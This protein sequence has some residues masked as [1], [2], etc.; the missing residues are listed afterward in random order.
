[1]W[2]DGFVALREEHSFASGMLHGRMPIMEEGSRLDGTVFERASG[3]FAAR[4]ALAAAKGRH[5]GRK[6]RLNLLVPNATQELARYLAVSL[7][8]ADFVHRDGTRVPADE[9]CTLL[10]GDL[11][12]VT[13]NIR[14]C[15]NLLRGLRLGHLRLTDY[16]RVEVLS[17]YTRPGDAR[18][19][20]FVANPGWR[21]TLG[22][23]RR[24]GAVVIDVSHPRTARHLPELLEQPAVS[25]SPLQVAVVPPWEEARLAPLLNGHRHARTTWA[26]DPAAAAAVEGVLLGQEVPFETPQRTIWVCDDEAV[27]E[28]LEL[29]H[30]VLMGAARLAGGRLP[31]AV[32][33]AWAVY[34]RLRQ[35]VLPLLDVEEERRRAYRT[36]PLG[37]RLER[38]S[39]VEPQ[40]G[41]SIGAYLDANWSRLVGV[42][43][44]A[45]TLLLRRAEP[46]KF[47]G[48]A[49]AVTEYLESGDA[50]NA[51]PRTP[52]RSLRVV[53][54]TEHEA[55]L[56]T[57]LMGDLV[58][59]WAEALQDGTVT[60]S[61]AREEPRLV[62]EGLTSETVI[63]GF[64]TGENRYLD[65]YPG[66]PVH[67]VAYPYELA[68]DEAVQARCHSFV[69]RLQDDSTRFAE[70]TALLPSLATVRGNGGVAPRQGRARVVH[71]FEP[72]AQVREVRS[73]TPEAVEPL[74]VGTIAGLSWA[75]EVPI[76]LGQDSTGA[77]TQAPAVGFV[78][79]VDEE[80]DRVIYPETQLLDV[81][82][83]A[84]DRLERVP[85]GRV[86]EGSLLVVL[87][88]DR[89]DGL[90][91]R[92][93][94]ASRE[95]QDPRA[96]VALAFWQRA[97]QVA[98][99]RHGGN[100]RLLYRELHGRGL[101]V[102][103]EAVA[104]YYAAG[105][106]EVLA[107]DRFGDFQLLAE[108]SGVYTQDA[109]VRRAFGHVRAERIARRTCG[110]LLHG[111]LRRLAGGAHY[112]A[113]LASAQVLGTPVEEVAAAVSLCEVCEARPLG[114]LQ[115]L[116]REGDPSLGDIWGTP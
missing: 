90:F 65:V 64:R 86:R 50:V 109:H 87:V 35:L 103:Y 98:L 36:L 52:D 31:P 12:F 60:L 39:D 77:K 61:T 27:A 111:L 9:A 102:G 91:R 69:E 33:E 15:V 89:Y 7:L 55:N 56:L 2:V 112:E 113:A 5:L 45:Y 53:V 63:L 73:A 70:L 99:M 84:T 6:A 37:E 49:N 108:V 80:G 4:A 76:E 26:W 25:A 67:V 79:I 42:L 107:P 94:E 41:G 14:R 43:E 21:G 34:H 72:G 47:Y 20:V 54:P 62:A 46:A 10:R 106:R 58:D 13:Q 105:E 30:G 32:L 40:A 101:S 38:L 116:E 66:V 23:D 59:G 57:S 22:S 18:P 104:S 17:A 95:E 110:R 74:A 48:L 44:A 8:M 29:A 71:R 68:V 93:L 82:F 100:R 114:G 81:Y 11:L 19:R 78:E 115:G 28:K 75:D 85:A 1:M 3:V 83:A 51:P 92:F 96:A 88:D 24:F 16:W 97:K